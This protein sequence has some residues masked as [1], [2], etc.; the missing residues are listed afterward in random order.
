MC[1]GERIKFFSLS[2]KE[3]NECQ[4]SVKWV[5]ILLEDNL[6]QAFCIACVCVLKLENSFIGMRMK[7]RRIKSF[8]K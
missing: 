4:L 1:I 6:S 5:K 7:G 8:L 3:E 2:N